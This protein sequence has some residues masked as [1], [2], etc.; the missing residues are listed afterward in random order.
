M[1]RQRGLAV[2]FI[3]SAPAIFYPVDPSLLQQVFFNL[4]LNAFRAMSPGGLLTI[5]L[6]AAPEPSG[7]AAS[8]EIQFRDTGCGIPPGVMERI[9]EPGFSTVSGAGLGL[10]VSR[11]V[12][13]QHGGTLEVASEEGKGTVFTLRFAGAAE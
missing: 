5:S 1:A 3:R 13:A 10:A 12:T 9:F 8:L 2:E 6:I 4:A 11:A 7:T